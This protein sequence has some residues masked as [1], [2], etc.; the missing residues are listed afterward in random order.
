MAE[1]KSLLDRIGDALKGTAEE[2]KAEAEAQAKPAA[3]AMP[4]RMEEQV[5][6]VAEA[7]DAKAAEVQKA[8]AETTRKFEAQLTELRAKLAEKER[9]L[10][11]LRA[12]LSE[13]ERQLAAQ[14]S[15]VAEKTVALVQKDRQISE[16]QAALQAGNVHPLDHRVVI[17]RST[18]G[19][20]HGQ[21][22]GRSA[23]KLR[24][25]MKRHRIQRN[26]GRTGAG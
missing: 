14:R 25:G 17:R 20:E 24:L 8:V 26:H 23:V 15:E 6:R 21:Q 4:D 1:P 2:K 3:R 22:R 7:A 16:L 11:D 18:G 12:R 13:S 9:E 19:L 10:T 5:Q